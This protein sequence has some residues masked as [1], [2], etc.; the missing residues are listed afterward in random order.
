MKKKKKKTLNQEDLLV[1]K[2]LKKKL[3]NVF[4]PKI[5]GL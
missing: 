5:N 4:D 2:E 1:F 3:F